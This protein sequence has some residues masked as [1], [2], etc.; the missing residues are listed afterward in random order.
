MLLQTVTLC[1]SSM[2][3][4]KMMP[5]AMKKA[6]STDYAADYV[7]V[8]GDP[9]EVFSSILPERQKGEKGSNRSHK[10]LLCVS[11]GVLDFK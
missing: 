10:N 1:C 9:Q 11:Y 5:E 6:S 8:H 2:R 3:A 7:G 4:P